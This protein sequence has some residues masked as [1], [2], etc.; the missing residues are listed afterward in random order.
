MSPHGRD[1]ISVLLRS[2][3]GADINDGLGKGFRSFL[4]QIVPDAS[5]DIPVRI[6][7]RE[8]LGVSAGIRMR[9]AISIAFHGLKTFSCVARSLAVYCIFS[10]VMVDSSSFGACFDNFD[11]CT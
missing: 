3:K 4:G 7:A 9:C 2:I 8:F 6:L 5:R 10:R 1:S 11:K